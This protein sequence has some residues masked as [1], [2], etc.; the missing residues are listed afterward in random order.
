MVAVLPFGIVILV[1][2][3]FTI[4]FRE[5]KFCS[6]NYKMAASVNVFEMEAILK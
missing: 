3:L 6:Y 1:R 2:N 4:S 5:N